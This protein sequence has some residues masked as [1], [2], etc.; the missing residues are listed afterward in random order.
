M[1][2]ILGT[3]RA[4]AAVTNGGLMNRYF[5][6]AALI[7]SLFQSVVAFADIQLGVGDSVTLGGQLVT[8]GGS[9][10]SAPQPITL[11]NRYC[12][13]RHGG[14]GWELDTVSV[15]SD[16]SQTSGLIAYEAANYMCQDDMAK[17]RQCS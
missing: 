6:F 7:F 2:E 12:E 15:Y 8:C 5:L 1:S 16:G 3:E 4:V 17:Q 10:S 11:V 13:C 14:S 9:A